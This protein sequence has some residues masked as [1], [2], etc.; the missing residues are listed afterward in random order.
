MVGY[1]HG[2]K[3]AT[4]IFEAAAW[5]YGIRVTCCVCGHSS[6]FDPHKLWWLFWKKGWDDRLAVARVRFWCRVC[7]ARTGTRVK[8]ADIDLTPDAPPDD[9]GLDFPPEAEW[10]KAV[11]RFR[12]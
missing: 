12:S 3:V 1:K 6:V 2:L 4:H 5:H 7:G 10:K 9:H 8:Q 11:S